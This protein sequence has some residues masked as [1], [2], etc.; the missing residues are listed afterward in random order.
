M[1]ENKP[2]VIEIRDVCFSTQYINK[3]GEQ[4][5]RWT[6]IGVMFI[7]ENDSMNIKLDAM[8]LST[9]QLCCFKK[10]QKASGFGTKPK[11]DIKDDLPF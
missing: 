10:E 3:E 1:E 2:K 9:N 7:K 6:K 5:V 4:K 8:P 11:L